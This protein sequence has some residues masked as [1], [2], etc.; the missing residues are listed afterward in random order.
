MVELATKSVK[1]AVLRAL[2]K[3]ADDLS[4]YQE[5]V[6]DLSLPPVYR[7]ALRQALDEWEELKNSASDSDA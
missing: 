3:N 2:Q 1:E 6:D 4:F 7:H 5:R